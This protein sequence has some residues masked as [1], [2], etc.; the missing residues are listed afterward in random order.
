MTPAHLLILLTSQIDGTINVKNRAA[1]VRRFQDDDS[2]N[3]LI[4]SLQCGSLGLNLT[5]ANHVILLDV[6]WNPQVENQA[7]VRICRSA[8]RASHFWTSL[9]DR[10][11]RFG[12]TRPVTV[13]K[14]TVANS[15]EGG[16]LDAS[17]SNRCLTLPLC[18]PHSRAAG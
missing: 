12:Q 10:A 1:A 2:C 9:Q 17:R 6:W 8:I 13:Y 16:E 11:H 7:M 5:C 4:I 18:R 14:V 3:V 15:V